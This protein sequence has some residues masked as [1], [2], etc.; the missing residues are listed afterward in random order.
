MH[1][2]F[3]LIFLH[4]FSISYFTVSEAKKMAYRVRNSA[5][6][7]LMNAQHSP[8]DVQFSPTVN[9]QCS[10]RTNKRNELTQAFFLSI[11]NTAF[12]EF[13]KP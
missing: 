4:S 11:S 1:K 3:C 2:Q 5:Y 13:L 10:L 7:R 12:V 8:L 6:G 9:V